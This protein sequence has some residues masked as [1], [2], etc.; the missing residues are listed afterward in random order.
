MSGSEI[1]DVA[2]VP[3]DAAFDLPEEMAAAMRLMANPAV[4]AIALSALGLGIASHAIGLWAGA[5]TGAVQAS[6]RL[7]TPLA[8]EGMGIVPAKPAGGQLRDKPFL[9]VVAQSEPVAAAPVPTSTKVAEPVKPAAKRRRPPSPPRPAAAAKPT[10]ADAPGRAT[11][12]AKVETPLQP[13]DFHKPRVIE[14]PAA[15]DDLKAISGIGPKLEKVLN[16]LGIWTYAQ[17]AAWQAREI[18]WIDDYL[19]FPGRIDRDGWIAQ[20]RI[21]AEQAGAKS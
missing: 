13:E 16:G 11:E 1:R 17:I 21:L 10:N 20:A 4:G 6:Q 3:N 14:R 19:G 12:P 9:K 5:L 2:K 8:S 18:A 7:F 15:P